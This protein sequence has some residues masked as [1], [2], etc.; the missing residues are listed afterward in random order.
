MS[1]GDCNVS[2]CSRGSV[3]SEDAMFLRAHEDQCQVKIASFF[4][5][6]RINVK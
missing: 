1:R 5:F 2:S 3:S 6:T 4:M